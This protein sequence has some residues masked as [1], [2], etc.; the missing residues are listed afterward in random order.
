MKTCFRRIA[1]LGCLL[2]PMC[3]RFV[4]VT[5]HAAISGAVATWGSVASTPLAAESGV[6]AIAA[7]A[8]HVV[9]LKDDGS[10]VGW[11]FLHS[12]TGTVVFPAGSGVTAIAAGNA[13]TLALKDG[14]VV[15]WGYNY[16]GQTD[17]P[18]AARSG[19]IAITAGEEFSAALKNDGSVV[20]WGED[21]GDVTT[22]PVAAQSGV[23]AIAAGGVHMLALKNDGTVVAW[24]YNYFG[25]VTGGAPSLSS[26]VA[27]PVTLGGQVLSGVT[28]I[29]AG[30]DS[31]LALKNDGSVVL[32]GAYNFCGLT[33][34][35]VAAQSGVAAIA[36]GYYHLLA[37]KTNGTVVAWGYNE[38][39]QVT[40]T[41][42][43]DPPYARTANPVTLEGQVLRGVTAIAGGGPHFSA[44]IVTPAPP[45]IIGS[46]ANQTAHVWQSPSLTVT[47][48]GFPLH[49]QWRKDGID[50]PG[51]TS[52]TLDLRLVQTSQAGVYTVVVSNSLGSVT[53]TPTV[54]TV[55]PELLGTVV[56][57]DGDEPGQTSYDLGQTNV[58]V[59]AQSGVT[60]IAS[61]S[62][63]TLA[64]KSD[65][66]VVAWG[67]TGIGQLT[68]PAAA[69]SGVIAIAAGASH[70]VALKS[71]GSVVAWGAYSNQSIVPAAAMSDV[72]AISAGGFN[73]MVLKNDG[74][75][76]VWGE[77]NWGQTN[78]PA[79]AQSGV[80]AIA[81][82]GEHSAALKSDGSVV[83]WGWSGATNVP[84]AA[85]SGVIAIAAGSAHTLALKNNGSV[86]GWGNN[87]YGQTTVPVAAQS[88]VK[89]I[90]AGEDHSVALKQ[91]GTVVVWGG[92][93]QT[94]VPADLTGVVGISTGTHHTAALV[95]AVPLLPT[96]NAKSSG[97]QLV[98]SWPTNAIGFTLQST[99]SLS[100]AVTWSD[101][102]NVPALSGGK[103]TVT[104]SLAG[105]ARFYRL[106]K[107]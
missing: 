41:P 1:I 57:W 14:S 76:F 93:G 105:G 39:G 61:G 33:N 50:L 64:L 24:G 104:N 16:E 66:S 81:A 32:W 100:P 72:I 8:A 43:F 7:G 65:G 92:N 86:V 11:G 40:G 98:L 23:I 55:S 89:A 47:A 12:P 9:V 62:S 5:S 63:H 87:Y 70:S 91:N 45:A 84:V 52:A 54:L 101:A 80:I 95:G 97:N 78:V 56:V 35:P 79:A 18:F 28:A 77:N 10:V 106:H 48:T 19:V 90:T 27:N 46:P 17:V 71:D 49:Y 26:A 4:V 37:L 83:V 75:V 82:G 36:A 25:Q 59:A 85:Q 44:A 29:A 2:A 51:A 88:G 6:T 107:P 58:P 68:V 74:S 96:L 42:S 34:I 38:Y 31:S 21:I 20:V 3:P 103:W 102:S 73:T 13:H 22:V 94:N 15:A 60:A 69:Q 30:Y 99:P 67:G 53:S